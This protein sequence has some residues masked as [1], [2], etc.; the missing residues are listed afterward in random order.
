MTDT[1][2]DAELAS[3]MAAD[4]ACQFARRHAAHGRHIEAAQNYAEAAR[5][6]AECG[7]GAMH[8]AALASGEHELELSKLYRAGA[9]SGRVPVC[10]YCDQTVLTRP[11]AGAH[12]IYPEPSSIGPWTDEQVRDWHD[13]ANCCVGPDPL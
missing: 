7:C 4:L 9:D 6:Y 11:L 5:L 12:G 13:R 3:H 8:R 10:R 1:A 2:V